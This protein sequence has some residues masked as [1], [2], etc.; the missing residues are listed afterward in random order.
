MSAPGHLRR[1][2]RASSRRRGNDGFEPEQGDRARTNIPLIGRMGF[3]GVYAVVRGWRF[4]ALE[5]P[6]GVAGSV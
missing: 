3:G 4:N 5:L 6:G 1:A 2:R